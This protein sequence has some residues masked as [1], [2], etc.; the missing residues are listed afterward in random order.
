MAGELGSR[1]SSASIIA[2]TSASV[3]RCWRASKLLL[4]LLVCLKGERNE[5]DLEQEST[6]YTRVMITLSA[7]LEPG[8]IMSSPYS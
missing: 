8:V 6:D 2:I 4:P 3:A 7:V 1:S 5:L